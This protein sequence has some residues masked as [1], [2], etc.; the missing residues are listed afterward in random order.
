[1]NGLRSQARLA[2]KVQQEW[3][4]E[5]KLRCTQLIRMA[6]HTIVDDPFSIVCPPGAPLD[7]CYGRLRDWLD[8]KSNQKAIISKLSQE[9]KAWLRI[10]MIEHLQAELEDHLLGIHHI[11]FDELFRTFRLD[12]YLLH[13][14]LRNVDGF[15]TNPDSTSY[16]FS[17]RGYYTFIWTSSRAKDEP[18]GCAKTNAIIICR[19]DL[20]EDLLQCLE[21]YKELAGHPSML[22]L[23]AIGHLI[24][25]IDKCIF[26]D[27]RM[28]C[29]TEDE[30]GSVQ[31]RRATSFSYPQKQHPH[32]V[33]RYGELDLGHLSAT[34]SRTS[35]NLALYL[36]HLQI[37]QKITG[38]LA[39][40]KD[41]QTKVSDERHLQ[42]RDIAETAQIL[43]V[44]SV[45]T[46]EY[47][48]YL[49]KR[50]DIQNAVVRLLLI[51]G[52][53]TLRLGAHYITA[54]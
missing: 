15:Y 24:Q 18:D 33:T 17:V 37:A 2:F 25:E 46:A 38:I 52:L 4:L 34:M 19:P 43:L 5:H 23:A 41:E 51:T 20:V 26:A 48:A 22:P 8:G 49:S 13:L 53:L 27:L 47:V 6:R 54:V 21:V 31:S 44:T 7:G 35:T 16:Y 42:T 9:P 30:T 50:A 36:K 11:T 3:R 45:M 10:V 29:V 32:T 12:E 40:P 1:M 28:I 14:L 39:K